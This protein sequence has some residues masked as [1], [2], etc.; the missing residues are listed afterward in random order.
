MAGGDG[1]RPTD[2]REAVDV[3]AGVLR[4]APED[5]VEGHQLAQGRRRMV[6]HGHVVPAHGPRGILGGVE[7]LPFVFQEG[8]D[9]VELGGK[10]LQVLDIRA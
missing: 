7:G 10:G 4:Q 3:D 2:A 6:P 8:D 9:H 5:V 1:A